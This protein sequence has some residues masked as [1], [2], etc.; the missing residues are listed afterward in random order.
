MKSDGMASD[1][2][3]L[4]AAGCPLDEVVTGK[5]DLTE[6]IQPQALLACVLE[7]SNLQ[8]ALKQVRRNKGA[9]GIDGMTVDEL[10]EYLKYHWL[11]IRERLID[12]NYQP[13]SVR[14]VDIPKPDGKTRPLGIPTVLDRFRKPSHR[15]NYQRP[16]GTPL[17]PAQLRISPTTLSPSS[18][19]PCAS[20]HP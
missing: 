17:S 13:Q 5:P 10:P 16:M 19:A 14:R 8:R 6:S 2:R 11:E 18:G 12:G 3:K 15:A 20:E 9:P 4:S 7:R 1:N